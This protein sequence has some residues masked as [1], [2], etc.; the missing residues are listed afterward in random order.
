[1][2]A[3]IAKAGLAPKWESQMIIYMHEKVGVHPDVFEFYTMGEHLPENLRDQ[4]FT[5]G[6]P[7]AR[8]NMKNL[9]VHIKNCVKRMK[10]KKV[11]PQVLDDTYWDLK[12]GGHQR[13]PNV[14]P[15]SIE[16]FSS[17]ITEYTT[18]WS[19]GMNYLFQAFALREREE[20]NWCLWPFAQPDFNNREIDVNLMW[21]EAGTKETFMSV[22]FEKEETN[23][24]SQPVYSVPYIPCPTGPGIPLLAMVN[25]ARRGVGDNDKSFRNVGAQKCTLAEMDRCL[26][27]ITVGILLQYGLGELI[28]FLTIA[29]LLLGSPYFRF[30]VSSR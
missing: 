18:Q 27:A 21:D 22:I 11:E 4:P 13:L 9:F 10:S 2:I 1:M 6:D 15:S 3:E 20:E 7:L 29:A 25:G 30:G 16:D 8:Q 17:L 23:F 24:E 14:R 12:V 19:W 5:E 26:M 28:C